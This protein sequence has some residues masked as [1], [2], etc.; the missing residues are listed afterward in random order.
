[1]YAAKL[2]RKARSYGATLAA[3]ADLSRLAGIETSPPD[4]LAPFTRAVSLAVRVSDPVMEAITDRPT[5]LYAQ[6][7]LKV[8]ALLDDVALRVSLDLAEAGAKALPLPASQTLDR[9]RWTSYLSHK[10]VAVAAG[11]GWQGKSLLVVNPEFGPRLRLVTVLTD[12]PLA[13][14]EPL[15]NRCGACTAP[16]VEAD[17][18]KVVWALDFQF[19][20]TIDGKAVKIASMLDE[21]TRESLLNIVERSI[22]AQRLIAE[23]RTCFAAA[24][25]ASASAAHGQ[26]AGDDQP[27][28][29]R[30]GPAQRHCP[31]LHRARRAQ[32]ERLHRALQPNVPHRGARCLPVQFHRAGAGD[33]RRLVDPAQRV[34]TA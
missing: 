13:P 25:G 33:R 17:A 24:G 11:I 8:N 34:P 19:D 31:E 2:K 14:D 27:R 28:L 10:A 15:T 12:A 20:S 23:L 7:Y 6:H 18:P 3:V 16:Q 29:R 9:E 26:R 21:H 22:T 30:M 32:S 4:L 1:M 5:P